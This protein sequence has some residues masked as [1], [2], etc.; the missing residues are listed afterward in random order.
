MRS[1]E[2]LLIEE[3]EQDHDRGGGQ[4]LRELD[5][6]IATKSVS[7]PA[8]LRPQEVQNEFR[9]A[10]VHRISRASPRR[11]GPSPRAATPA[12]GRSR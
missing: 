10:F 3:I 11:T 1:A 6:R 12:R 4:H 2:G 8:P 7:E 9:G 5:P